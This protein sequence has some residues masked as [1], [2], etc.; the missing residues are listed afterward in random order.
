MA[1]QFLTTSRLNNIISMITL[2]RQS[3][4]LRVIRGQ[5]N[6][7]ELGQIKFIDGEPVT[8]L[9]GQ[10][11][12]GNALGVLV[13][14]GECIYSFDEVSAASLREADTSFDLPGSAGSDP[15]RSSPQSGVSSG[16]W[17]SYGTSGTYPNSSPSAP[18]GNPT[19]S[20]SLPNLG[21]QPGYFPQ[22]S[23]PSSGS[24][25]DLSRYDVPYGGSTQTSLPQ[26]HPPVSQE[27]LSIVYRRSILAE[28]TDQ[29]PLDRRERMGLLLV[30]GRRTVSDLVRL[31]RRSDREMVAVLDHLASL[32]LIQRIG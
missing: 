28:R 4:I 3:G 8:A 17:P 20:S 16:S 27:V 15:G 12:G 24:S 21:S 14:W 10:L 11:T 19:T 9:L 18:F 7:R 5:G 26:S 13:N 29:L 23:V 25:G 1:A 22:S 32:G 31:T 2:G 6:T 30:D